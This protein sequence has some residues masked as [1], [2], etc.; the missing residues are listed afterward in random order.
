MLA[1]GQSSRLGQSKQLLEFQGECLVN[2]TVRVCLEAGIAKVLV[3]LG[4]EEARVRTEVEAA[5]EPSAVQCV[6][7]PYWAQGMGASIAAGASVLDAGTEGCWLLTCDQV[8]M[9]PEVLERMWARFAEGDASIV[10]CNYG[11]AVGPPVLFA[12]THFAALKQ[13]NGES[14]AKSVISANRD[15]VR[16]VLFE[17]G[18][19]DIDF[20]ED[21]SRLGD[22]L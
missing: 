1:A 17:N 4:F 12:E 3:V 11:D 20:P 22:S 16:S 8:A 5:F 15:A 14:G 9:Q 7:N 19:L 21:L 13:L 2:R 10:N 18:D 6:S